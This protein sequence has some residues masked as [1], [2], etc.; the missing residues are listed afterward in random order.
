ME[1]VVRRLVSTLDSAR[2]EQTV[3]TVVATAEPQSIRT[4]CLGRPPHKAAFL[5]PQLTWVFAKSKPDIVHSRNWATIEAIPAAKLAGVPVVI[6]SEH[7]RDLQTMVGQ[8]RRRRIFRRLSLRWTDKMFCVSRELGDYY[9]REMNL[10]SGSL[11]VIPNGVDTGRFRPDGQVRD[12]LRARLKAAPTTMVIGT[13]SRLDP[14][15]DHRTLLEAADKVLKKGLD[16]R[17][18]IIG[19]G[20]ERS[21]IE[22]LIGSRSGLRRCTL[23]T[24]DIDNVHEW[25]NSFDVFV[26]PSLSEGMS[27]TLLEA[28]AMGVAP[29]ATD[30]GGNPEVVE[31]RRSGVLVKMRDPD[32]ISACLMEMAAAEQW[33]RALGRNARERVLTHFSL[34]RMVQRYEQMYSELAERGGSGRFQVHNTESIN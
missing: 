9:C 21:S 20:P 34:E 25:L 11:D 16:L 26:L 24:G 3:C 13:V 7:G 32:G 15:K 12:E 17:V 19:D 18:V 8:P 1:N 22:A 14:V 2:F 31:H 29:I 23:L 28:M 10:P 5:V 6:H 27:N 30:V 4:V 33:R